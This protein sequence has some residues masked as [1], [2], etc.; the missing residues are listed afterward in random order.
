MQPAT[1]AASHPVIDR[2]APVIDSDPALRDVFG[3]RLMWM[4]DRPVMPS[5][6]DRVACAVARSVVARPGSVALAVPRG[7]HP[8]ALM[9]GLHLALTRRLVGPRSGLMCGS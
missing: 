9:V 6:L 5:G 3:D 7:K 4:G 2:L 8:L 1:F